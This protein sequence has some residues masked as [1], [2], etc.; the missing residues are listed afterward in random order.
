M[1]SLAKGGGGGEEGGCQETSY[2]PP[3]SLR[4]E[5]Q[6]IKPGREMMW[7]SREYGSTVWGGGAP[8]CHCCLNLSPLASTDHQRIQTHTLQRGAQGLTDADVVFHQIMSSFPVKICHRTP[9]LDCIYISSFI[10]QGYFQHIDTNQ[11]L[12]LLTVV[13]V[14]LNKCM[15][16]AFALVTEAGLKVSVCF[17]Q[18][19]QKHGNSNTNSS[20]SSVQLREDF[21]QYDFDISHF[22][23]NVTLLYFNT[24]DLLQLLK[25]FFLY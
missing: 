1:F 8:G 21:H 5:N 22:D 2:N 24:A 12:Y 11:N 10:L 18:K 6:H 20:Y 23:C 13:W 25:L 15:P 17:I 4:G 16:N 7:P 14:K 3:N 19:L 9:A